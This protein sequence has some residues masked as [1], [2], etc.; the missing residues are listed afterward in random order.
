MIISGFRD[1]VNVNGLLI[2]PWHPIKYGLHGKAET[3]IFPGEYFSTYRLPSTSMI[4][5]VLENHHIMFINGVKCITLGHNFTH[6]PKLSHPYY[7][8]SKVIENLMA[9]FPQDYANG[10]IVVN[11]SSIKPEVISNIT[12]HVVYNNALAVC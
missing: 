6:D 7:G 3:W 11:D 4:T 2:T 12:Q 1:Y 10:R 9:N 8:T 5:L